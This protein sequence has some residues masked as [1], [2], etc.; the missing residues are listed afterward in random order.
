MP[1]SKLTSNVEHSDG[2]FQPKE[3]RP[4]ARSGTTVLPS[5]P[6]I[7]P[8]VWRQEPFWSNAA[9]DGSASISAPAASRAMR[10]S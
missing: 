7:L 4:A 10:R 5:R 8:Q 6:G 2:E 3:L 9:R 1:A